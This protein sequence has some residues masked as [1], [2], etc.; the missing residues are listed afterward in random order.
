[1]NN[2]PRPSAPA[3]LEILVSAHIALFVVG[4][5]WAFGGN[6]DWVR[7]PISIWGSF[8]V[9]LTV[10]ALVT[11]NRDGIHRSAIHWAWP[12]LALNALVA[13]SC[14]TPGF[15]VLDHGGDKYLLP[16]RIDWWVPSV[17]RSDV[18]LRALWLFDGIYFSCLN[19]A[20][21]VSRRST[22]RVILA[23]AVGNAV[24][25]SIFGTVQKLAAST[26]IFFG[27]VATPHMQFFASFVYDNHWGAFIILMMGACIGLVIR[28]AGGKRG[29]GFF[30]GPALAGL[31]AATLMGLSV[32]FSGSRACTLLLGVMTVLAVVRGTPRISRALR[33]SGIAPT[34]ALAVMVATA[35]LAFASVWVIAGD[36]IEDRAAKTKNQVAE[37]WSQGGL[38]S[39]SMLYHDTLRMARD[40]ILFGWGMGSYPTVFPLYNLQE[41]KI[42]HL[43]VIYH[44]AHSDWL[45]SAAEVGLIGTALLGA[46][47]ALPALGARKSRAG[48]IPYFLIA[49]CM[50]IAAYAWIEFPFGNVAVVLS[51]W[52]CYF[53]AVQYMRLT[54]LPE[55]A[56][57]PA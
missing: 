26:G 5:S 47:A 7:T 31:L 53:A 35:I 57:Q 30:R 40:R 42:D 19:I 22:L 8:G 21:V 34:A 45:Q 2:R 39:R 17:A 11:R 24:A 25:L 4:V 55:G 9:F 32:P 13:A 49:G 33:I 12:V 18:A 14:L 44:D 52:F 10:A 41:S 29:A 37:I 15:R 6:A 23:V 36:V 28:Y 20:L 50:L 43:P 1:M 3:T 51:W 56:G 27:Q 48:P 46:S 16:V 38:G 54:P